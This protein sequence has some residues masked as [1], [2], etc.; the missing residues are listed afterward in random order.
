[1]FYI[2]LTG[3]YNR[4]GKYLQRGTDWFLI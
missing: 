1:L 3:F 4:A 2:S